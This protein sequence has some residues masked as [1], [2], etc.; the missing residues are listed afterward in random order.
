MISSMSVPNCNRFYATRGKK[1]FL[2]GSR[3]WCRLRSVQASLNM[4]GR[5]LTAEIYA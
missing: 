5:D 2:G 4:K 1:H 3:L